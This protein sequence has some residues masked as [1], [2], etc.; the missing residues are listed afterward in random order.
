M[1]N[2][3]FNATDVLLD[4]VSSKLDCLVGLMIEFLLDQNHM[5]TVQDVCCVMRPDVRTKSLAETVVLFARVTDEGDLRNQ[6]SN[7]EW[8]MQTIVTP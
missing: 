3:F 5:S 4:D 7:R 8:Q 6:Q 1:R 2:L